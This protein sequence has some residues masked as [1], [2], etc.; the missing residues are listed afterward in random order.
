[1]N[2][3]VLFSLTLLTLLSGPANQSR[4]DSAPNPTAGTQLPAAYR[5]VG[6]DEH[7]NLQLPIDLRFYD[8]N[9][10]YT[11]LGQILRPGHPM[12]LQLGYLECP[13][14]CDVISRGVVDSARKIDLGIGT[15]YDFT[16][17]SIDPSDTP[18][19]ATLKR[20]SY[21]TEYD[22]DGSRPGF[23]VLVGKPSEIEQLSAAAGFRYQPADNGQFA[24]P[25]VV[26]VITPEGKISRYLYGV[27]FPP[28]VLRLSLVEASQG[29]IG[30]TVDQILLI[31][32]HW[33]PT[34][35]KY[36]MAAMNLV[37]VGG[38]ITVMVLGGAI[39]WMVKRGSHPQTAGPKSD[40]MI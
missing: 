4:A 21:V 7:L 22:R 24:H 36:S 38:V 19:L 17:V 31:C 37:R 8:E 2:K 9:G 3:T 35:G 14:L 1:M 26:M 5:N 10:Q 28:Q 13:M 33:D 15:D 30:S 39:F 11:T 29:K 34:A 18:S 32:L 25:A 20:N 27:T 23:H 16:F 6:V 12:I 40:G